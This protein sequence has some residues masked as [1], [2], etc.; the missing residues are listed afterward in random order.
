MAL[1]RYSL[2]CMSKI[3][4]VFTVLAI[5]LF[6]LPVSCLQFVS[7][8]C[9]RPFFTECWCGRLSRPL[10]T[11]QAPPLIRA[12]ICRF[13]HLRC[14]WHEEARMRFPGSDDY[15]CVRFRSR[16]YPVW[17]PASG[18]YRLSRRLTSGCSDAPGAHLIIAHRPSTGLTTP[19]PT[20]ESVK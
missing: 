1:H 14:R 5:C 11:T 12:V 16:L 8:A 9:L 15:P 3:N 17:S 19:S 13:D 7:T 6:I 20:S 10:T 2:C 4:P 18:P